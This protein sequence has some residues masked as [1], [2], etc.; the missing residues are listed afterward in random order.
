M[1]DVLLY[2]IKDGAMTFRRVSRHSMNVSTFYPD[3]LKGNHFVDNEKDPQKHAERL[4]RQTGWVG[5]VF[6]AETEVG[7]AYLSGRDWDN[8]NTLESDTP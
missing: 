7:N 4:V 1:S 3:P 6:N 2:K 5:R 8:Q